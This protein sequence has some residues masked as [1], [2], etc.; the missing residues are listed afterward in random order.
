MTDQS[1]CC[2]LSVRD[3]PFDIMVGMGDGDPISESIAA[4]TIVKHHHI[5]METDMIAPAIEVH[6]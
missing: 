3:V 6:C 1:Q 2:T 4:G 5:A